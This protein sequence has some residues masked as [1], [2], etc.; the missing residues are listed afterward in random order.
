M[1]ISM[2]IPLPPPPSYHHPP[3]PNPPPRSVCTP[4]PSRVRWDREGGGPPDMMGWDGVDEV[5]NVTSPSHAGE[6]KCEEGWVVYVMRG[7]QVGLMGGRR[8]RWESNP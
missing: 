3:N 5:R 4:P 7:G 8:K 6:G 2:N 1:G